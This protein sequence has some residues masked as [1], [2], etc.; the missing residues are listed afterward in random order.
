[1]ISELS[2][3]NFN[4]FFWHNHIFWHNYTQG[5]SMK[6]NI[7]IFFFFI[8]T[9]IDIYYT[10]CTQPANSNIFNNIFWLFI[11]ITPTTCETHK[12]VFDTKS[13]SNAASNVTEKCTQRNEL[14]KTTKRCFVE[15]IFD[16]LSKIFS[17]S[18]KTALLRVEKDIVNIFY[19]IS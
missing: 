8:K 1:M 3:S 12:N 17:W 2:S 11:N 10:W 19:K 4:S 15:Y 9:E 16:V 5:Y 13:D 18:K 6:K 7:Y 14:I